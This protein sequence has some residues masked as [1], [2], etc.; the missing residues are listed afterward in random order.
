ML[1]PDCNI[2]YIFNFIVNIEDAHAPLAELAETVA[3]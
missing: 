1:I 3:D 2:K